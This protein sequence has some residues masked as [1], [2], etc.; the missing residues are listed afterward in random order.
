M[1]R[2][3]KVLTSPEAARLWRLHPDSLKKACQQGRITARKSGGTWLVSRTAMERIYGSWTTE[4]A[5][6]IE[7]EEK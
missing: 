5:E 4:K 7:E 6:E 2:L 1:G 3:G